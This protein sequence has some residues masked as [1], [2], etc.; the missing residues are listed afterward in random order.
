MAQK[1]I[2]LTR[3][4]IITSTGLPNAGS[5]TR[6]LDELEAS[7]FILKYNP[8][9]KKLRNS[10]YQLID[11]YS[12]FYLKFIKE[13]RSTES[14]QWINTIDNPKHRAWS[15]YAFEQV[16]LC[17]LPQIKKALGISGVF[18]T[19]SSWRSATIKSGAQIDL[20]I[21]RRD[22]VINLCET[23]F[24]MNPFVIDSKYAD[25]L[26]NKIGVFK[27]ETKTRKSVFLTMITT[28]GLQPNIHSVGLV[29][30]NIVMD[31]LF[32]AKI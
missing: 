12:L 13:N 5:T 24:S 29:Q 11:F 9:G 32:E 19:T 2:G 20:V 25:E 10:I 23:K 16:C 28:Y 3:D 14:N 27:T 17:H 30:N 8:L 31:D 18:S 22:H 15:G 1:S 26:R 4:E 7:G 6:L 21:D